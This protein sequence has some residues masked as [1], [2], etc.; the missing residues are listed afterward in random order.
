M[1]AQNYWRHRTHGPKQLV[2]TASKNSGGSPLPGNCEG[3][4]PG[5]SVI[6]RF[7]IGLRFSREVSE[8]HSFPFFRNRRRGGYQIIL[9]TLSPVSS[10]PSSNAVNAVSGLQSFDASSSNLW[11]AIS[12]LTRS[13]S[14]SRRNSGKESVWR[15]ARQSAPH[16]ETAAPPANRHSR[17]GAQIIGQ[18][19]STSI[20]RFLQRRR[21]RRGWSMAITPRC[22]QRT[23]PIPL[24]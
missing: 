6:G 8:R 9:C 24:G 22:R 21:L 23:I 16:R 19:D 2:P 1:L 11:S 13:G 3:S 7:E 4:L 14:S 5:D 15:Q 10:L 18:S 12:W 17:L 20:V